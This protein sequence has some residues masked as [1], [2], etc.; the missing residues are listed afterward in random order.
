MNEEEEVGSDALLRSRSDS[1]TVYVRTKLSEMQRSESGTSLPD[2][3][4][5]T[6]R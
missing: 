6:L 5:A 3:V 1:V 4:E 2:K